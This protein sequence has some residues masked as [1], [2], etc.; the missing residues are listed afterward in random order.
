[1]QYSLIHRTPEKGVA[2]ACDELGVKILAYSP[3]AQGILT[4][5]YSASNLPT[6]P[7]TCIVCVCVCVCFYLYE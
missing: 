5:R 7:H 6:G 3:L 2:Q 4:G 1:V